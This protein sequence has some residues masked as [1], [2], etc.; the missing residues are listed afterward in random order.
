ME[1][2][3]LVTLSFDRNVGTRDRKLRLASGASLAAVGWFLGLPV[4]A[5]AA[6][7]ILG[8]MWTATGVLSKC[9]IYYLLGHSTRAGRASSERNAA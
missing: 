5:V 1:F 3:K 4:W 8:L 9:S 6:T 2:K 7:T